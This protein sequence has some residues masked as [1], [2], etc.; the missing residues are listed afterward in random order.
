MTTVAGFAQQIGCSMP[1]AAA[2]G[3]RQAGSGGLAPGL[4]VGQCWPVPGFLCRTE[5]H[6]QQC[7]AGICASH[8]A[9][10]G[11][12]PLNMALVAGWHWVQVNPSM[13]PSVPPFGT[14]F[15]ESN[16]HPGNQRKLPQAKT[17]KRTDASFRFHAGQLES[18]CLWGVALCF[19]A[20]L[21]KSGIDFKS[22][23]ADRCAVGQHGID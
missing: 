9:G 8:F 6:P 18:L 10:F 5:L 23:A 3:L 13:V 14:C 7:L 16:L 22:A 19:K 21:D 4:D 12:P 11:V 1:Q 15:L 17:L 20:K 2:E